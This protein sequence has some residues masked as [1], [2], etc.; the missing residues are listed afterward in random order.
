MYLFDTDILSN[1][2]KKRPSPYLIERLR[3]IPQEKQYISSITIGEIVYGAFK[4][5]QKEK[6]LTQLKDKLIPLVQ[7]IPFDKKEAFTY[8]EIRSIL[9]KSGTPLNDTDLMI[10]ATAVANNLVLITGNEKHFSVIKNLQ[11]ENWLKN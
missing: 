7:L 2:V 3:V 4:S 8:G 6:H 1:L 10:A 11:V 9:E 5:D